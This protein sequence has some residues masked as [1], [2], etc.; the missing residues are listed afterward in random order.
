MDLPGK[1][2]GRDLL[3]NPGMGQRIYLNKERTGSFRDYP[4]RFQR[5][6]IPP[7]TSNPKLITDTHNPTVRGVVVPYSN[8]INPSPVA[9]RG[10]PVSPRRRC[11][12]G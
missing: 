6:P 1:V 12:G 10:I 4:F 9:G 5:R 11:A 8:K 2:G 3:C 7:N